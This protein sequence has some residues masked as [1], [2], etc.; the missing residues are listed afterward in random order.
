M[1]PG[2]ASVTV[3]L[4]G[5]TGAGSQ[6]VFTLSGGVANVPQLDVEEE[7][8]GN[9]IDNAFDQMDRELGIQ[10]LWLEPTVVEQ[11]TKRGLFGSTLEG[12]WPAPVQAFLHGW[13]KFRRKYIYQLWR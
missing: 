12:R 5:S 13:E 4:Q 7:D 1:L 11:G 3:Q 8:V 2:D 9:A 10:L 6:V